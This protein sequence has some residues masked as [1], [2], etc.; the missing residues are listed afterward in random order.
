MKTLLYWPSTLFLTVV[1]LWTGSRYLIG[2]PLFADKIAHL[3]YP[4]YVLLILGIWKILAGVVILIKGFPR[5][6][7]WAYAGI[8]FELTGASASH[9]FVGDAAV[10]ILVP[11]GLGLVALISWVTRPESRTL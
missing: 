5:L 8:I 2:A 9:A 4:H 7:E 1:L 3:G 11:L 6:K 10:Y